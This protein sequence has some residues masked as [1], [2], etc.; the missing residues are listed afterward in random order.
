MKSIRNTKTGKVRRVLD[1]E[2]NILTKEN[3][4]YVSKSA[5]KEYNSGVELK[6]NSIIEKAGDVGQTLQNP[7][8]HNKPSKA[9]KRHLKKMNK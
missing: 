9:T 5:W 8:K 2:A 6:E 1:M 7:L 3:W 4:E